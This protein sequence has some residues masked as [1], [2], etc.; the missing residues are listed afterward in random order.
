MSPL[1]SPLPPLPLSSPPPSFLFLF[2]V[3]FLLFFLF[4]VTRGRPLSPTRFFLPGSP[5]PGQPG[6]KE[7]DPS[8]PPGGEFPPRAFPGPKRPWVPGPTGGRTAFTKGTVPRPLGFPP[9]LGPSLRRRGQRASFCGTEGPNAVP[10]G[11]CLETALPR[12]CPNGGWNPRA[13]NGTGDGRGR[14]RSCS[15][16]STLLAATTEGGS[17]PLPLVSRFRLRESMGH[18]GGETLAGIPRRTLADRSLVLER[19]GG[20]PPP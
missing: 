6:A 17:L 8:S 3:F 14:R 4:S 5:G 11:R 18:A 16:P 9:C 13:G 15:P 2:F 7:P 20:A 12:R 1:L 19:R 10:P